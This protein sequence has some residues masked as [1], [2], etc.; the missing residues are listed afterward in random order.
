MKGISFNEF[1][2]LESAARREYLSR[3]HSWLKETKWFFALDIKFR[4]AKED[5]GAI[6]YGWEI[7]KIKK[8]FTKYFVTL[9]TLKAWR[10]D[11]KA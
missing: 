1:G 4:N 10:R 5:D 3:H 7:N 6:N 2:K 9:G 8:G 11:L